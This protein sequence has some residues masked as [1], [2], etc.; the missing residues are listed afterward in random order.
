VYRT[1]IDDEETLHE[2]L[3]ELWREM[4]VDDCQRAIDLLDQMMAVV[5]NDGAQIGHLLFHV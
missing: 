4:R 3:L 1:A 5:E 2:R